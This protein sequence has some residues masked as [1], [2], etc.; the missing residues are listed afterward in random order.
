MPRKPPV[1]IRAERDL[2]NDYADW[3]R[4][5]LKNSRGTRYSGVANCLIALRTAPEWA[6]VLHFN[7]SSFDTV[8][9]KTPP[10]P[11]HHPL[12]FTWTDEDDVRFAAWLQ[13]E[14]ILAGKETA[15]QAIQTVAREHSFHPI[16]DYL[17]GL[18]WDG[19]KRL[20]GW[21][22][23]YLGAEASDYTRAVGAKWLIGAVA[24]VFKPGCKCDWRKATR[25]KNWRRSFG[26][27][28]VS[29]R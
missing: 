28:L 3:R 11:D 27:R 10:W 21:L 5:L 22:T 16:R 9:K 4:A 1:L 29:M 20:D 24:R 8:A 14:G 18:K 26:K 15:G 7:E 2:E 6:G 23:H 25:R 13:H 17:T 19:V 12:P